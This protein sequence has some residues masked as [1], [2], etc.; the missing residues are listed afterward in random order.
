MLEVQGEG[1]ELQPEGGA[2]LQPGEGAELQPGTQLM[3]QQT[4]EVQQ[5]YK[6]CEII[7]SE[8]VSITHQVQRVLQ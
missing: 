1:E 7:N 6:V 2:E 8:K 4:T 5:L 3:R